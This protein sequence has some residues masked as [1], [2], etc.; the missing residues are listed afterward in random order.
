MPY[1]V[2]R[3]IKA[4]G[5]Y[6]LGDLA[7]L[8]VSSAVGILAALATDYSQK[9]ETSA[10][11]KI[12]EWVVAAGR[13]FGL[14]D[15]PLWGVAV[16][17]IG[18]GA[19]SIFYFQPLTRIGAFARGFGLL[20]AAMTATPTDLVGGIEGAADLLQPVQ[21]AVFVEE[22]GLNPETT[23]NSPSHAP[24]SGRG[25]RVFAVQDVKPG[26]AYVVNLAI[27]FPN[28]VP[29]EVAD[30]V[31]R[32]QLRGRL[33]NEGTR[34]TFNLFQTAGGSI[35][36]KGDIIVIRA[37]VPAKA[38]NAT[39]WVRIEAEGYAIEVQSAQAGLDKPLDWTIVMRPSKTP[40]AIQ[41]LGK[42]YWF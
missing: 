19:L 31:R 35:E 25:A 17:L 2:R 15:V 20:A 40:L 11:Y 41:R 27:R 34:E 18:F 38:R 32:D 4:P 10:L 9:G 24:F 26:A 7:S 22:A 12:N 23:A 39:L 28:G 6:T 8:G 29:H 21:P 1:G 30:L 33:H 3:G 16:G 36:T 42:S 13:N 14:G 5:A 37:G